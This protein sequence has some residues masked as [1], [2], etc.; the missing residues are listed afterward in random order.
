MQSL[1]ERV[2]ICEQEN[3]RLRKQLGRQNRLWLLGLLFA[4]GGGA[5]AGGSL[6]QEV[7]D[8]VKAREVVVVDFNGT[9]RARLGG[10]V[11]DA[12]IAGGRVLKRGSK[13]SGLI[14][15]DEQGIERGGYVTQDNGSNAMLTLDSKTRQAALFVAGPD[16]VQASALQLW[17]KDSSIEL[18]SDD[19]GSRISIGDQQGVKF[20][21]P[22][23]RLSSETCQEYKKFEQ[24]TPGKRYCQR[25]FTENACNVCFKQP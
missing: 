25:R 7:F 23:V 17:T 5:L 19:N 22:E 15:Y 13:A 8:S 12:V 1:E 3:A 2:E 21:Q 14:I 20:Q 4:V 6:K 11:P 10:D 24:E 9:V 16:E 18:R